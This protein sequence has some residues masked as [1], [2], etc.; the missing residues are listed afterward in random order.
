MMNGKMDTY[1][2]ESWAKFGRFS[3]GRKIKIRRMGICFLLLNKEKIIFKSQQMIIIQEIML[4]NI[5]TL[6]KELSGYDNYV[7][8]ITTANQRFTF[9]VVTAGRKEPDNNGTRHVYSLLLNL[10]VVKG[11]AEQ[12]I[13]DKL[14]SMIQ[15]SPRINV[16]VLKEV[17]GVESSIFY[18][19]IYN[20]AAQLELTV[21]G[22]YL[23]VEK[24]SV[25]EFIRGLNKYFK[26]GISD[27]MLVEEKLSCPYC[28][29]PLK[30]N[31]KFCTQCGTTLVNYKDNGDQ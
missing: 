24:I 9:C 25:S 16:S 26:L 1:I 2:F 27:E 12:Q 18:Q 14:K 21:D 19:N 7:E 6:A 31:A 28:G 4:R 15:V 3:E 17:L 5:T 20:L 10:D 13:F 11:K 22:D 29:S 8:I 30:L 23:K